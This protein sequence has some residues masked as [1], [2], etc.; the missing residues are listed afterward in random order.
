MWGA[1]TGVYTVKKIEYELKTGL[2]LSEPTVA[3]T[4][5]NH[6][7]DE[8]MLELRKWLDERN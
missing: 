2:E 7:T 5:S 1:A 6:L 4:M 8:E 3:M